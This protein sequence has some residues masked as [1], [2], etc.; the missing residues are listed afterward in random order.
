MSFTPSPSLSCTDASLKSLSPPEGSVSGWEVGF[1]FPLVPLLT[2]IVPAT[3]SKISAKPS[4]SESTKFA[5]SII[6]SLSTSKTASIASSILFSEISKIPS[7][8]AST[9]A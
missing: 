3:V 2:V 7:F 9:S 5:G 1:W 4:P 8:S 6:P